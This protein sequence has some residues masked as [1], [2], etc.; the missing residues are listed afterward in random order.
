MDLDLGLHC[1]FVHVTPDT[2]GLVGDSCTYIP[3]PFFNTPPLE[4]HPLQWHYQ[5]LLFDIE[6]FS[7][8]ELIAELKR[9]KEDAK[10]LDGIEFT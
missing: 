5:N 7:V 4:I 6:S 3:Q 2:A 8:E 1:N 9:R 10:L